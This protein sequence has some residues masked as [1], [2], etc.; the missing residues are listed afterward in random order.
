M[1]RLMRW[2]GTA[3]QGPARLSGPAQPGCPAHTRSRVSLRVSVAS[4][5]CHGAGFGG[6]GA[7]GS[8]PGGAPPADPVAG[9]HLLLQGLREEGAEGLKCVAEVRSLGSL[10]VA[11][12]LTRLRDKGAVIVCCDLVA[13][14]AHQQWAETLHVVEQRRRRPLALL[15]PTRNS[16]L[17]LDEFVDALSDNVVCYLVADQA[18]A[19]VDTRPHG[20]IHEGP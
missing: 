14:E 20:V 9:P 3:L 8:A 2:H 11:A 10:H 17:W 5:G 4:C 6:D 18:V 15:A 13:A 12:R 19:L 16:Q 7:A 1:G